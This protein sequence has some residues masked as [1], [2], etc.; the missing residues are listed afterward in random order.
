MTAWRTT[1][2]RAAAATHSADI[3]SARS[4]TRRGRVGRPLLRAGGAGVDDRRGDRRERGELCP[5]ILKLALPCT[6]RRRRST[7]GRLEI[8]AVLMTT[9]EIE[10]DREHWRRRVFRAEP[11][12]T[13]SPLCV[14]SCRVA[15]DFPSSGCDADWVTMSHGGRRR[16]SGASMSTPARRSRRGTRAFQ[17]AAS[18]AFGR[19][20]MRRRAAAWRCRRFRTPISPTSSTSARAQGCWRS[21]RGLVA[22]RRGDGDG[23]R[24]GVDRGH[25]RECRA[26]Q[27]CRDRP[28]SRRR[29]AG[30]RDRRRAVRPGDRE[31]LAGPLVSMAPEIAAIANRGDDDRARRVARNAARRRCS[32]GPK[33]AAVRW[34]RSTAAATG[35]YCDCARL[36]RRCGPFD[37]KGRDG[38]ALDI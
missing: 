18:R 11:R 29:D 8:D 5:L 7:R 37:P 10:D 23:Y 9:E 14:H 28:G 15:S 31:H 38:W 34:R 33:R 27:R 3:R 24:S 19:G 17:I 26:E 16:M 22:G 20:I 36:Q 32:R 2:W 25:A 30:R 4:P 13:W 35:A 12:P 6:H 21:R 1:I